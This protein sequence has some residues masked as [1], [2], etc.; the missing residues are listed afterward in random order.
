MG[1]PSVVK[2]KKGNVEYTSKV[3]I[4]KYTMRELTRRALIDVG[5]YVNYHTR[6]RVSAL[7]NY[8]KKKGVS[9][10][11][12]KSYKPMAPNRYQMWVKRKEN[13][14]VLG[15]ENTKHGAV[16]AWWADQ[17]ELGTNGQPKRGFLFKT[18]QESIPTIVQIEAQYL[19]YMNDEAAALAQIQSLPDGDINE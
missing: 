8:G 18:V 14:L 16:S 12:G 9:I 5:R 13:I 1:V 7:W 10:R 11:T 17:S 19:D 6:K 4:A 15:I 2:I 3:D